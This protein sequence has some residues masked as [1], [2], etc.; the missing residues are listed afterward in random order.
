M[1]ISILTG[2]RDFEY[3]QEAVRLDVRRFLLKPSSMEEIEEAV[4]AMIQKLERK[5]NFLRRK[6]QKKSVRWRIVLL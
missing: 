6:S 5:Q 2:Y 4:E 1:E 3:A